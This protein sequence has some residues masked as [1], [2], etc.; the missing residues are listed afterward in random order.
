M[1]TFEYP[2]GAIFYTALLKDTQVRIFPFDTSLH[3]PISHISGGTVLKGQN[4]EELFY[5]EIRV[6]N[7]RVGYRNVSWYAELLFDSATN[8]TSLQAARLLR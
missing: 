3:Q 2:G 4:E 8:H 1:E 5:R 7:V 6:G